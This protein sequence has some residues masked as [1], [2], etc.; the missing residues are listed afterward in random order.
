MTH[1]VKIMEQEVTEEGG[2][3]S[4]A[5]HPVSWQKEEGGSTDIHKLLLP[6]RSLRQD[7]WV[8]SLSLL[9]TVPCLEQVSFKRGFQTPQGLI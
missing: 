3:L 9:S 8:P 5:F 4:E 7:L 1:K 2:P 6:F